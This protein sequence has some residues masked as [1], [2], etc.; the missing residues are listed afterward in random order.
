MDHK[1]FFYGT[2]M[3]PPVL[4]RIIRGPL[5]SSTTKEVLT[6]RVRPAVLHAYKRHRIKNKK[7][8]AIRPADVHS[9]VQGMLVEGLTKTDL[10]RLDIYEGSEY[11]RKKVSVRLACGEASDADSLAPHHTLYEEVEVEADAYIWTD[12]VE[13]LELGEWNLADFMREEMEWWVGRE[14]TGIRAGFQGRASING[15]PSERSH[16][17]HK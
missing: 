17:Y 5:N 15:T 1:A 11:S 12:G 7:Y 13:K 9:S 6:L 16:K 8:P 3:A 4:Y 2:L 14:A 10:W